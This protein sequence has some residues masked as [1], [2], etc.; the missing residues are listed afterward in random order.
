MFWSGF[1]LNWWHRWN[2]AKRPSATRADEPTVFI[3]L[4]YSNMQCFVQNGCPIYKFTLLN[5]P[6]AFKGEYKRM[7][8]IFCELIF[9]TLAPL[10]WSFPTVRQVWLMHV[11][12]KWGSFTAARKRSLHKGSMLYTVEPR[13][14]EPPYNKALGIT[15][16]FLYPSNSKIFEKELRYNETSL[17]RTNLPVPWPFV[18]SRFHC[19][20]DIISLGIGYSGRST[21]WSKLFEY[22]ECI[23]RL[24][25]SRAPATPARETGKLRSCKALGDHATHP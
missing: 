16:N 20:P 13:Y 11:K 21:Q 14:N 10:H 24:Y 1:D 4:I 8:H 23:V 12:I 5:R 22:F 2:P 3:N 25:R 9:M 17:W 15:N 19:N 7:N 6:G 18:I